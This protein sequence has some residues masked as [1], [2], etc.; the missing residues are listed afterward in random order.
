MLL[1]ALAKRNYK[2]WLDSEFVM[3]NKPSDGISSV[4]RNALISSLK[5]ACELE[6]IEKPS[7]LDHDELT[8][9]VRLKFEELD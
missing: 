1:F 8:E 2:S 3:E 4:S 7:D 5:K 9:L 6:L